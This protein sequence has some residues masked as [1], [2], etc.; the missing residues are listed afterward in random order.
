MMGCCLLQEK[1]KR[2][3]LWRMT[4]SGLLQHEGTAVPMDP[5]RRKGTMKTSRSSGAVSGQYY[6]L[7]IE[8]LAVQPGR[9]HALILRKPDPRRMYTQ[10]WSFTVSN[11]VFTLAVW[12]I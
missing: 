3:Q 7:D 1:G 5:G 8:G 10:V 9:D 12:F 11:L 6:V 2:S 4:G